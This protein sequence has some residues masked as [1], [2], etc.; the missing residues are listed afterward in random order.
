MNLTKEQTHILF[1]I[2]NEIEW[3]NESS[4]EAFH[5]LYIEDCK[6]DSQKDLILDLIRGTTYLNSN[7]YHDILESFVKEITIRF[8]QEDTL[9]VATAIDSSIDSSHTVLYEM[10]PKFKEYGWNNLDS[11]SNLS[12]IGSKAFDTTDKNKLIKKNIVIVDEFIGSGQTMINRVKYIRD[13]FSEKK[14]RREDYDIFIYAIAGTV[15]GLY[16]LME[17][18]SITLIWEIELEQ[19]ISAIYTGIDKEKKI[20]DMECLESLLSAND[21]KCELAKMNF[22]YGGTETLYTRENGNTPNNVFPIFWW[23]YYA[24]K[25]KRKTLMTRMC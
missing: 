12:K 21:G 4:S 23:S 3:F 18:D 2:R 14:V 8:K 1:N 24:N 20:K 9:V 25:S 7:Q 22:G 17:D 6:T 10:K 16:S 11:L 19:G 5:T 15:N 13:R